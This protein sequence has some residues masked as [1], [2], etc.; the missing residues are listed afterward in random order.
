MKSSEK[1]LL[2]IPRSLSGQLDEA[3]VL[4]E[5]AGYSVAGVLKTRHPRMV[6]KGVLEEVK[7]LVKDLDASTIIFYGDLRPSSSFLGCLVLRT[8]ATL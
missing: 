3:L 1:A 2:I 6:K 4:A 5:T 8:P 7:R